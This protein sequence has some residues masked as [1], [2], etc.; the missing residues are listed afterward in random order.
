MTNGYKYCNNKHRFNIVTHVRIIFWHEF[1]TLTKN[2][3]T[4]LHRQFTQCHATCV[5]SKNG[6]YNMQSEIFGWH[7]LAVFV[8]I[9]Q[10]AFNTLYY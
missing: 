8:E 6:L 7:K 1:K 2:P 9:F 5:Q 10:I 4:V 3:N